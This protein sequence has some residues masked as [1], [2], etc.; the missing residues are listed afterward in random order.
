MNVGEKLK[1]LREYSGYSQIDV[2]SKISNLETSSAISKWEYNER[3]PSIFQLA[4]L[5]ELYNVSNDYIISSSE[6]YCKVGLLYLNDSSLYTYKDL[7]KPLRKSMGGLYYTTTSNKIRIWE[8][9]VIKYDESITSFGIESGDKIII[10]QSEI[11]NTPLVYFYYKTEKKYYIRKLATYPDDSKW[12]IG[13]EF[14]KPLEFDEKT[15]KIIGV[16]V[17]VICD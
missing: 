9:F 14:Q 15:I 7:R 12:L 4:E 11:D 10:R 8:C 6:T 5:S 2:A 3:S 1:A 16:V 13:E 17:S